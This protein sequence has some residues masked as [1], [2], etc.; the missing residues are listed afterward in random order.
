MAFKY[1]ENNIIIFLNM[2][3]IRDKKQNCGGN[4]SAKPGCKSVHIVDPSEWPEEFVYEQFHFNII[5]KSPHTIIT[6]AEWADLSILS[7]GFPKVGNS[8]GSSYVNSKSPGCYLDLLPNDIRLYILQPMCV[9]TYTQKLY[10][11]VQN[12]SHH[13]DAQL[14]AITR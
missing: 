3:V 12:D 7:E 4:F 6:I 1:E 2:I 10:G 14:F 5:A 11:E 13:P 9:R 8:D